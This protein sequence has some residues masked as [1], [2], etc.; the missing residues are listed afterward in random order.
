MS[1]LR[2]EADI[3]QEAQPPAIATH[4]RRRRDKLRVKNTRSGSKWFCPG[5]AESKFILGSCSIV[6]KPIWTNCGHGWGMNA[7]FSVIVFR[8]LGARIE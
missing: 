5:G 4:V 7:V 2:G 3:A 6:E 8:V 1:A